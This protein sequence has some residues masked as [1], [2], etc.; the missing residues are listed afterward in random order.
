MSHVAPARAAADRNLL[1][2][3][4]AVQMDF[5][6]RDA[7]IAAMN[8]WVLAK[9]RSL[10][11]IFVEHGTMPADVRDQLE[12][13][14]QRHVELHGTD[15][16]KSL[17]AVNVPPTVLRELECVTDGD[18]HASIAATRCATPAT[19]DLRPSA[20]S[21]PADSAGVRYW[22][23]RPHARGGLGVVSVARDAELGREV[24]LKEMQA[25]YAK[26]PAIR[27]RF[28][29]EAEITGRLEHPGV[30]PVY[31]LGRRGDG[32]PYYAMRFVR[33]E[34]LQDAVRK[35]HAGTAGYTLRGLLTRFVAVCNTVAYAHS[36]GVIHRDL[37]PANVMLGPYGETLVVDWGL[38][39]VVGR[40][41]ESGP[42]R[43]AEGTLYTT[44]DDGTETQAGD[45]MGTPAF[46]SPEQATGR[47]DEQGPATDVYGLGATLYAVLTGQGPIEGCETTEAL[48]RIRQGNWTPPGQVRRS[49]PKALEAV[50]GKAMALRPTD[51]YDSALALAADVEQW[52][53]GEPISAYREP[54]GVTAGRWL[55]RH[56]QL[57]TAAAALL[58]AA[59]P[60]SLLLAA[61]RQAALRQAERSEQVIRD[62]KDRAESGEKTAREREAETRAV[63]DF[64]EKKVFAAARPKNQ[65]GGL[66]YDVR[67]AD[68]LKAALPYVETSFR[69][70]PLVEARLRSTLATSFLYLGRTAVAIDQYEAARAIYA[71]RLGPEHPDTLVCMNSLASGYY[72][73]GRY[74][75]G[76]KLNEQTLA[77]FTTQRGPDDP[78]TLQSMDQL[79]TCYN[80]L[81]RSAEAVP[82]HEKVLALR[83]VKLGPDHSLTLW[84]MNNLASDY[85]DCGRFAEAAA[86]NEETLARRKATLGPE[87]PNTLLSMNNVAGCYLSLGRYA[88]ALS[89]HE[90]TLALQ[91]AKLGADHPHTLISMYNIA[92][93]HAA[94]VAKASDPA[95]QVDLAMD[96]LKKAV[97]AGFKEIEN[98][99]KDPELASLRDRE[100]FKKLV[101]DLEYEKQKGTEKTKSN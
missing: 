80:Q 45:L 88:E 46:M 22:V 13:L 15:P 30:V 37:K 26:D 10:G 52:L 47:L 12:V 66:G 16:Q 64:V 4:L 70:Q 72:R 31:G 74:A 94:M 24:A 36:R 93:V 83:K 71:D 42:A 43:P 54:W 14:V 58:L 62:E 57:V 76:A 55:R 17:A 34:T 96:H 86:L 3:I 48:E 49:V 44:S 11:D 79:A 29:R 98:I 92:L 84:T 101:A 8:A 56:R 18:L 2:G 41:A 63:L 97:A 99:K 25:G 69:D 87:H 68:A 75:D 51:R 27:G 61:N 65:Q 82:L 6:S 100:D 40:P 21:A 50:C 28:L 90:Q 59:V 7:L 81:G 85:H 20:D 33:G 89:L 73:I 19:V 38:A 95:K 91:K 35:L 60:L 1:F 23:I 53:A 9:H 5:A 77:A 32:R 78:E 39:K 67:L